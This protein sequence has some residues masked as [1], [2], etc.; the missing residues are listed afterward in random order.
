MAAADQRHRPAVHPPRPWDTGPRNHR[1][2]Q[3]GR[4]QD[5]RHQWRSCPSAGWMLGRAAAAAETQAVFSGRTPAR[6]GEAGIT[7]GISP[8]PACLGDLERLCPA[9][10]S[11][12]PPRVRGSRAT[13]PLCAFFSQNGM[14][15]GSRGAHVFPGALLGEA[16]W[17]SGLAVGWQGLGW[18]LQRSHPVPS[19]EGPQDSSAIPVWLVQGPG[20]LQNGAEQS[21]RRRWWGR[22]PRGPGESRKTE[23]TKKAVTRL[24]GSGEASGNPTGA[25]EQSSFRQRSR[26]DPGARN[27]GLRPAG[28]ANGSPGT[29]AL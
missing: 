3:P 25:V 4:Q 11:S 26:A 13:R 20:R 18:L 22:K 16:P 17:Q 15:W 8:G 14:G 2:P 12:R 24:R 5:I 1:R 28:C 10:C 9:T 27:T 19:R 6:Q 7:D 29:S 21:Q 23:P